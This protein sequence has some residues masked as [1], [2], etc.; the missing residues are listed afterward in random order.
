MMLNNHFIP[1]S[2]EEVFGDILVTKTD[3][4]VL[5]DILYLESFTE[6]FAGMP[7][8]ARPRIY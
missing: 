1:N 4:Q 2:F 7:W 6:Y 8:T 3:L 5:C